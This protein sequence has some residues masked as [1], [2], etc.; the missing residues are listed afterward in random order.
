MKRTNRTVFTC[1]AAVLVCCLA[2][3]AG[4]QTPLGSGFTYQGQL[5]EAGAPFDGLADFDFSLW[6]AEVDG[7]QIDST[8][9]LNDVVVTEGV[10]T[11]GLDFGVTALNGDERWL[12]ISVNA[13]L[14]APRQRL[15]GTPYALQTR[16]LF[17]DDDG[18][19]GIGTDAPAT[20]LDVVGTVTAT[21]FAGDGSGL[22]NLPAME[23]LWT[24]NAGSIFYDGGN[25]GIGNSDPTETLDIAGNLKA[26]GTVSSANSITIDGIGHTITSTADLELHVG[27]GSVMRLEAGGNVG[28]GTNS[29]QSILQVRSKPVDSG[30]FNAETTAGALLTSATNNGGG[31]PAAPE[32]ALVLAR[33]GVTGQAFANYARFDLSRYEDSGSESRSQLDIRLSYG[34]LDAG[35]EENNTPTVLSLRSDGSVGIGTTSPSAT[36]DVV[37]TTEL[38]GD[39]NIN[40]SVTAT[41]FVG[42]GS[43]LTGISSLSAPGGGPVNALQI[44]DDGN[45]VTT[46]PVTIGT[47]A[48]GS[49]L[50]TIRDYGFPHSIEI[51]DFDGNTV[52][53][54]DGDGLTTTASLE[55]NGWTTTQVLEI[56]GGSDIAEPYDVAPHGQC[57]PIPGMEVSIDPDRL[58]KMRVSG[59]AYDRKVAG[60]ISG[61][62]GVMPG[63]TLTQKGTVADGALP[64]ASVGRVWCWCDA[65]TG[66]PIHAGDLLTSSDTP[67]HAMKASQRARS[68]GAIIGKAMSSLSTG[69]GMVLVLV[70]LQ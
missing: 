7:N 40:G 24:E 65:D 55:V 30:A 62:N 35:N 9:S 47:S 43:G 11:V 33:E 36:L 32:A 54:V 25:V 53:S 60:I 18:S 8:L 48:A 52:F 14:L 26:D 63:L 66:G 42:D 22:T 49:A 39:V 2:P 23:G 61:A 19:V 44:D 16:G 3:Q 56:T 67:G 46:H 70:S 37:G 12:Q 1:T 5:Q 51:L 28:I 27:S 38:N 45:V 64:V 59:L 4:A 29:P 21:S 41:S 57:E 68:Q 58:G 6:D 31:I 20:T 15:A 50:L 34:R 17:V 13:T 10:F 69:R